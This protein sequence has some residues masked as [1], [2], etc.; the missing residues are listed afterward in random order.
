MTPFWKLI[1]DSS[2]VPGADA[3]GKFS[4]DVPGRRRISAA[5]CR[6]IPSTCAADG[7]SSCEAGS[8]F[9]GDDA[10]GLTGKGKPALSPSRIVQVTSL[11]RTVRRSS[12]E[13]VGFS[14]QHS[15]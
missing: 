6:F 10:G 11:G 15:F 3:D 14:C 12:V 8:A 2:L 9:S 4:L 13:V 1:G 7:H 5:G